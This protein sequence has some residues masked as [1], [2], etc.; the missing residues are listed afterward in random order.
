M[1]HQDWFG[2]V[3]SIVPSGELFPTLINPAG[4]AEVPFFSFSNFSGHT[5][6]YSI[7]LTITDFVNSLEMPASD[8]WA[9]LTFL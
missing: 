9:S 6:I 4:M 3:F 1:R 8:V 5:S 7:L 2:L